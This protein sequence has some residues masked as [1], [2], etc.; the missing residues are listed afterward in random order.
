MVARL[1]VS[2]FDL[3]PQTTDLANFVP[4]EV[5][6]KVGVLTVVE[7]QS[8]ASP[9]F[10]LHAGTVQSPAEVLDLNIPSGAIKI[11]GLT[12]GLPFRLAVRR[13]APRPG[14]Q[15]GP[16]TSWT[17]DLLV[18]NVEILLPGLQGARQAGG[19]GV[20]P[21]HLERLDSDHRKVFLVASGVLRLLGSPGV[22]T[23]AQLVDSP[24]P[25]DPTTPTGA[26][27]RLTARPP[28]FFFGGSQY[29]LTLDR[30]ELDLSKAFTPADVV[31]RGHDETWEGVAFKEVT[32]YPPPRNPVLENL[33]ISTRDVIV[34]DPG[35]LQGELR[36][37]WGAD[38]ADQFN[39]HITVLR[40]NAQGGDVEVART[41]PATPSTSLEYGIDESTPGLTDQARARFGVG[42][43]IP[44]HTNL[45]VVGVWWKTP[46]GT[47]GNSAVT[48]YFTVPADGELHYKL[49]LG[50]PGA[51]FP[52]TPLPSSVPDGQTEL[53]EVTV[54]FPRIG[55]ARPAPPFL[56]AVA[57]GGTVF[58]N[59]VHLRG[60]RQ[61]LAGIEL[62]ARRGSDPVDTDWLLGTGSAPVTAARSQ[63]FELPLL[64]Q[65]VTTVDLVA[66]AGSGP[67]RVRIEVVRTGPLVVGHQTGSDNATPAVVSAAGVGPVPAAQVVDTFEAASFHAD[68]DQRSA[69]ATAE[70]APPD[71]TVPAGA[72]AEV[73]LPLPLNAEDPI[74]PPPDQPATT[75]ERG[76]QILFQFDTPGLDGQEQPTDVVYP[77]D[78]H[79]DIVN[80][81]SDQL[82]H[83]DMAQPIGLQPNGRPKPDGDDVVA[84]LKAWIAQLGQPNQRKYLVVGRTDD[85]TF[86]AKKADNDIYNDGPAGHPE[87]GLA[88]RRLAAALSHLKAA[89]VAEDDIL[90]RIETEAAP[91]LP[92]DLA[93]VPI[94][95]RFS[96]QGRLALPDS[97][98]AGPQGA[99]LPV[100]NRLWSPPPD[101]PTPAAHVNVRNDSRR[102]G[103]RCAD[104]YAVDVPTGP[105]QTQPPLGD[106]I[107]PTRILVPGP[108]G[109]PPPKIPSTE[110][111]DPPLDRR[112]RLRARWDSPTVVTLADVVPT[113][114]EILVAWKAAET[115]L[116]ATATS[117]GAPG[118]IQIPKPTGPDFWELVLRFAYDSRTEQTQV[119]G[120]LSLP[121]GAMLFRSNPLA[122]ALAFGPAFTALVDP[123]D[124][125]SGVGT[126]AESKIVAAA[127]I[128]AAGAI[129]GE[130]LNSGSGPESTVDI[131]KFAVS[132]RWNG[133]SRVSATVDYTVDLHVDVDLPGGS[134]LK[135]DIKLRYKGVGLRFDSSQSGLASVG[136]TYDDLSV[137]VAGP[138]QWSLGGPLGNLIRVAASR[139]GNG[140]TWMELDLEFALDLGVV[141]LE[142]ATVR[143]TLQPF[144]AELRGLTAVVDVPG[145][146]AGK[147]SMT[148]S[149]AGAIRA[150]LA[151]DIIPARLGAYGAL[152]ID[153]DFV[154][155][156]V[157]VQF[158][159]GIPLASTGLGLYG[160]M[161]RFVA[162]GARN[163]DGLANP[164]PV[165]RELDWYAR[166]PDQKYAR[167]SGQFAVGLGAVIGTLPDSAFTFN[168]EGSLALGFP[169]VSVLLGIDAHL[170]QQRK[171][172]AAESSPTTSGAL[173][174]LGMTLF[175]PSAVMVAVRASYEVPK[176]IRL[177]IP[178]S[179]FYPLSASNLAW[180]IRLGTDNHPDRPGS[181]VTATL[182]PGLLDVTSW[183]F[184]M[185]EERQ[186]H[187]LGG[188]LVPADMVPT[189]DFDGY[190]IGL[191]A[192]YSL[193]HKAGP[194]TLEIA[195][196]LLV[197]LGTKPLLFAGAAG[198]RGE[199][200]LVVVSVG[201]DG[202]VH[203]HVTEDLQ[204][205]QGHF[206]GHVDFF[207]FSV[208]GC[209]DI[210][211]GD[212]VPNDI[213][214]PQSPLAGIDLCDHLSAVKAAASP[215][216]VG[217][218]PTVWPDTVAVLKF[219]HYVDDALGAPPATPFRRLVAPP[220]ALS[221]WSGSTELKYA[222]RLQ[223]LELF[224]LTGPDPASE[225]SWTAVPGPI[226]SAWWLPSHRRAVISG[227]PGPGPSTEEG[228]ELGLFHWD[229]RAWSRWLGEGSQDL[230]GDPAGT[231]GEIC[232]DPAPADPSCV[233]GRQARAAIGFLAAFDA[234]PIPG[235]VIPSRFT[236]SA[237]PG[238]GFEPEVIAALAGD[239]GWTYRPA[240]VGPLH[241]PVKIHGQVV[242]DGWRLPSLWQ[243]DRFVVTAPS[244][245]AFSKPLVA[246][247]VTLEVCRAKDPVT[248]P[249]GGCD[250][251]PSQPAEI[252]SFAGASGAKYT[253]DQPMTAT[254][255]DGQPALALHSRLLADH[256]GAVDLVRLEL[257]A[258]G[259]VRVVAFDGQNTTVAETTVAEADPPVLRSVVL[260]AASIARVIVEP[261][262]PVTLVRV[263]WGAVEQPLAGAVA[264]MPVT[265]LPALVGVTRAGVR[266]PLAP[267][268]VPLAGPAA[269][270]CPKLAY[271][272][273]DGGAGPDD[274][275]VRVEIAGYRA[276]EVALVAAC[277]VT[278]EARQAQAADG[279]FRASLVDLLGG[280]VGHLTTG[281]PTRTVYLRPGTTYQLR[282][283][284]Q[285]QGFRPSN[286]GEGPPPP[287]AGGWLA[288]A[289]DRYTFRTSA[290]GTAP[291]PLPAGT[292][293]L[294]TDPAQGGPGYDERVFDPRG[295]AR[296]L[297]ASVPDHQAPP[298]FLD[299]RVGF[300][301]SA[302]HLAS[303]VDRYN[304]VLLAKVLRTDP[305]AGSQHGVPP[306][307]PGG[308]HPLD[309]TVGTRFAIE[310]LTWN[311]ADL[312]FVEA[313]QAAPCIGAAP[314]IGS[315]SISVDADLKP[316]SDYDLLLTVAPKI[317]GAQPEVVVA[318]NHF[319]TSRYRNPSELAA[320]L[321]FRDPVGPAQPFDAIATGPIPAAGPAAVGDDLL[322]ALLAQL[323]LDPWPLPAGPR[324]T[325]VWSRP[326]DP[327]GSW[328]VAG[329]LIEADEPVMRPGFTTGAAGE[330]VSPPRLEVASLTVRRTV[331]RLVPSIPLPGHPPGPPRVVRAT[332]ALG[333]LAER[334]RNAAGTRVLFL[335]AAP[336]ALTGGLDYDLRLALQERGAAGP[337]GSIPLYDRPLI[338][339][340]EG[341]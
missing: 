152:A 272:L 232:G 222:F 257:M 334:V 135:G 209:V 330:P 203:F 1:G 172:G 279:A 40:K 220:A 189:L 323:G 317:V 139:I 51:T 238:G 269:D 130:L 210:H 221:P 3:L 241:G 293:S 111:S 223:R 228:R 42:D 128:L 17:L 147:G 194:F 270:T 229:P 296:Y 277:G 151:L 336:I 92:G 239:V 66:S 208:G 170:F 37:E 137:E 69:A 100:W 276:G 154:A 318:R 195:A 72:I 61:R 163:L 281:Q 171:A 341:G 286:P 55:A 73:E 124:V 109:P 206:C 217:D 188:N 247:E 168:A 252:K 22:A 261:A 274:G 57:P 258:G 39:S 254:E 246:G 65:D 23:T 255:V 202:L 16:P 148:V 259:E 235:S 182:Y 76:I 96:A 5:I 134:F 4:D 31:A 299:D 138:G 307:P 95:A 174:I 85:L 302:D 199:L 173:R 191:G 192:G 102:T 84:K 224:E 256:P 129:V 10:M 275:W 153:H 251:M 218:L 290:F 50:D 262:R 105:S 83:L 322:D 56:D 166:P 2:V 98:V 249:P 29:G 265:D 88:G 332:I 316:R 15:E 227:G 197:G 169:D 205:I 116:P 325:V 107:V 75:I 87:D 201:V 309:V 264:G 161:G 291:A 294:A 176:V 304:R 211:L 54:R 121:D 93:Q 123:A 311:V 126:D 338:V 133:E 335:A 141:R 18:S 89:G 300:W 324:T 125:S 320:A 71:V 321:G 63:I 245:L 146:I 331:E 27:L 219:G 103:Y 180:F 120:S 112:I 81:A 178:F 230:P 225:G 159:V 183:A 162:N 62:H 145:V 47:E 164:D 101:G 33:S 305:P 104:I 308:P 301:F 53:I 91:S 271:A 46:D 13:G 187:G 35:G 310:A 240:A 38:F 41:T 118:T 314:P 132:Y 200:D 339:F 268:S 7:H 216:P 67:R 306:P 48:P 185:I 237:T 231:V 260:R 94:P 144:S 226:D 142:G 337:A 64:A 45:G 30:F 288:G 36:V 236:V 150:L 313:A 278:V 179:A 127:A 24:D 86:K 131:D 82:Q 6:E 52:D 266:V 19:S 214:K 9:E 158:P 20:Q 143:I 122:G 167:H 196:F 248:P 113:E 149:D 280:L 298:H 213:P 303:L 177:N 184:L 165:Q 273:P 14:G 26:V 328:S 175:E 193:R 32:F 119:D 21:L 326:T 242:G 233:L 333:P 43:N 60:P 110:A 285:Y 292:A 59:V 284:W 106:D 267:A 204:Y 253:A 8:T 44:G 155:V 79:P 12:H 49:R 115:E 315:S 250:E 160:L 156:E 287:S 140:S 99:P 297:T 186:L 117:G 90:A 114:A 312:R 243:A 295:L 97:Q 34:G 108:D 198:V 283:T 340:Q 181:P 74:P 78:N 11:P 327:A 215:T 77:L 207:F 319:R 244:T 28:H 282:A 58:S 212:D 25:L 289:T 190:S 329:A 157:G 136:I 80:A 70:L 68:G 263:C 234:T